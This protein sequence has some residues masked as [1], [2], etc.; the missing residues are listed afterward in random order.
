MKDPLNPGKIIAQ[1][2]INPD[3][4]TYDKV[5]SWLAVGKNVINEPIQNPIMLKGS[6]CFS[7]IF[8]DI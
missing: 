6:H 4:K 8:L 3:S 2:A 5:N 1:M 7:L